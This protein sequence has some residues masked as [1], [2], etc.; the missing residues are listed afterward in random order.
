M[1]KRDFKLETYSET[2]LYQETAQIVAEM[3]DGK[4]VVTSNVF[5]DKM[6]VSVQTASC[7]LTRAEK[8]G[9]LV[10]VG[11][12]IHGGWR[13]ANDPDP[14]GPV[15]GSVAELLDAITRLD[16]G[17]GV[18]NRDIADFLEVESMNITRRLQYSKQRGFVK[19][20]GCKGFVTR[21]KL[22]AKGRKHNDR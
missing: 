18:E 14:K 7:R 12:R 9:L 17:D 19:N 13:P 22:T 5:A 1:H 2:L 15:P 10:R 21:W 11:G 20:S 16:N 3:I 4:T 6:G 8:H